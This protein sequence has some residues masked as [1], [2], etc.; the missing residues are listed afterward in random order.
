MFTRRTLIASSLAGIGMMAKRNAI[1][2]I[3]NQPLFNMNPL[4]GAQT[5]AKVAICT[6]EDQLGNPLTNVSPTGGTATSSAYNL[7]S[8]GVLTVAS[9]AS[10]V[11]EDGNTIT[12]TSDQGAGTITLN[13]DDSQTYNWTVN[14]YTEMGDAYTEALTTHSMLAAGPGQIILK[15]GTYDV[16]FDGYWKNRTMVNTLTFRAENQHAAIFTNVTDI[17]NAGNFTFEGIRFED[18]FQLQFGG[19]DI[20][21]NDCEHFD[22]AVD[23]DANAYDLSPGGPTSR[24][25]WGLGDASNL[26]VRRSKIHGWGQGIV[27]GQMTGPLTIEGCEITNYF[28][29]AIAVGGGNAVTI[30]DNVIEMPLASSSSF[31]DPHADAIQFLGTSGQ[32]WENITIERNIIY[33]AHPDRSNQAIFM[34]DMADTFY[35]SGTRITGNLIVNIGAAST[36]IRVMQAKGVNI[37]GNTVVSHLGAAAQGTGIIV[38]ET[39]SAGS[40][41]IKNNAADVITVSGTSNSRNNMILGVGGSMVPYEEA[42]VG[43]SFNPMNYN[44]ALSMFVRIKDSP[45]NIENKTHNVGATGSN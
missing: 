4:V 36:G 11:G 29:D 44:D 30:T 28:E 37:H 15:D 34:D 42:F 22:A 1:A 19:N 16:T 14:N 45:L 23:E 40:H 33:S 12:F 7:S 39:R 26:V 32:D 27:C 5:L 13:V 6:L 21:L 35:Y 18:Q 8:A 41:T 10:M 9:D 25:I 3:N 31:G 43:P 2:D 38:G 24:A 20:T 17:Y